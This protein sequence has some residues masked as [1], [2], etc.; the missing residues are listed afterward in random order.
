MR[1]RNMDPCDIPKVQLTPN[2][3]HIVILA[4]DGS[5]A[6]RVVLEPSHVL[7]LVRDLLDTLCVQ[8]ALAVA[9]VAKEP[10]SHVQ[11]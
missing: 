5:G 7:V 9:K 4:D 8:Q 11:T 3:E 10:E 2:N 6:I 1:I